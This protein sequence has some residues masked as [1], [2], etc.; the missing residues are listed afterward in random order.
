MLLRNTFTA[1]EMKQCRVRWKRIM[2]VDKVGKGKKGEYSVRVF[3]L[4]PRIKEL[5]CRRQAQKDKATMY[6]EGSLEMD[7]R[8]KC[9]EVLNW[10]KVPV[11][12]RV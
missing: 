6:W 9:H 2:K 5:T 1:T 12:G 8:K 7:L 11:Q 4:P 10:I 3:S